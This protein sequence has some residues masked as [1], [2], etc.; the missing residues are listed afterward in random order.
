MIAIPPRPALSPAAAAR[1]VWGL[2][3]LGLLLSALLVARQQVGGDQLNLLAR[4]WLLA[5]DGRFIS[6]GN[7]TSAGGNAPGGITSVLVGIPLF[8]WRDFRAPSLLIC[9]FHVLA[10]LLLDRVL[11][12]ILSPRERVL[13]AVLYWL[14]PWRV[15]YSGFLWNP[16]YL[17][18]F[19]AVH[20]WTALRQRWRPSFVYSLLHAACLVLAFQV[21]ASFLLLVVASGALCLRGYCK[22][23]WP[24]IVTGGMLAGLPL[25][26]WVLDLSR[27]P[28]IAVTQHGFL[29]RGL[30]YLFPL[31]RGVLYLLRY[32][33]LSVGGK[34]GYFDVSRALGPAANRMLRPLF[35]L[36]AEVLGGV[37]VLLP[38]AAWVRVMRRRRSR[39]GQHE[40]G[41]PLLARRLWRRLPPGA[42]DREWL[43]GYLVWIL[44]AA[45]LVFALAPTTIMAW[46]VLI[47][48]HAAV[49]PLVLWLGALSRRP[50]LAPWIA[51]GTAVYVA[52]EVLLILGL[53]FGSPNYRCGGTEGLDL[54]LRSDHPMLHELGIVAACPLPLNQPGTWWPDVLPEAGHALGDQARS[55]KT[56]R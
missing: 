21:H 18:L 54:A 16:N 25:V 19:G 31:L 7:P 32:S 15:Y 37:T 9:L 5:V 56:P 10:Y 23:S 8:L 49:L 11:Q 26:P 40:R 52:F 43:Q 17:Y 24:G 51:R 3:A 53:A 22:V 30:L 38:L 48:F 55:S 27:N 42:A 35:F 50:R 4:G 34:M 47:L 28:A 39:N 1:W 20:L 29:G 13:F 44:T 12:P 46:Q 36:L 14:S 2:F 33:S 6:Y 45:L 41:W